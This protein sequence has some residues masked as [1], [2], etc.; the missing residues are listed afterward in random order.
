MD[1]LLNT[2]REVGV[3]EDP[4]IKE[5]QNLETRIFYCKY[6]RKYEEFVEGLYKIFDKMDITRKQL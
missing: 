5:L 4:D 2:Y 1:E 6:H 3:I